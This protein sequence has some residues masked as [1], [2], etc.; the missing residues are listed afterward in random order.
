MYMAA[1]NPII[2]P[3]IKNGLQDFRIVTSDA[4]GQITHID[5]DGSPERYRNAIRVHVD[6]EVL[7]HVRFFL[8]G[9]SGFSL[10]AFKC[11]ANRAQQPYGAFFEDIVDKGTVHFCKRPFLIWSVGMP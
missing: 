1:D 4:I 11:R 8:V 5:M 2:M 9:E 6:F 3:V 7:R 10:Y